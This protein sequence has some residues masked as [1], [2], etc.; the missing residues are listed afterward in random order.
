MSRKGVSPVVATVLLIV[1]VVVLATIIFIWA[2]GFLSES[3]VKGDRVAENSCEDIKFEASFVDV[4]SECPGESAIDINNIGNIPIY[5]VKILQYDNNEGSV[6][7]LD[8]VFAGGT[9]KVGQSSYACLD[10]GLT[11]GNKFR[12]VPKILAEKGEAK[13]VYTCPEEDGLTVVYT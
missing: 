4:A 5:G 3:A 8:E 2:K 12:V 7:V 10:F 9:V 6:D 1:I 13:I 11:P